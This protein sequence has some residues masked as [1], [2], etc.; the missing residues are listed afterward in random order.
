MVSQYLAGIKPDQQNPGFMHFTVKPYIPAD[1][2]WAGEE[3]DSMYGMIRSSWKKQ[4][5]KFLLK[6]TIPVNTAAT[7]FTCQNCC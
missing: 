5:G 6:V 3:Y 1:L 4:D 2:A 7:V